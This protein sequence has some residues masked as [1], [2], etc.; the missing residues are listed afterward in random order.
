MTLK[1]Y[2]LWKD[3]ARGKNRL[4]SRGKMESRKAKNQ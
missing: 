1:E 2:P 3:V 4:I